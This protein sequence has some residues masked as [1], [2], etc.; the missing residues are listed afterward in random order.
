M[1]VFR[2]IEDCP[3]LDPNSSYCNLLQCSHFANSSVI[4]KANGSVMGF[5]SGYIIPTRPDT[6]FVWQVAVAREARG[7]GLASKMLDHLIA[8]DYAEKIQFLET[9]ITDDNK[10]SWALFQ[11][12]ANNRQ[13][14]LTTSN[15]MDRH[16]HFD[17][18]HDS[19]LLVRIGPFS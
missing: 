8:R 14:N 9:T 10:P 7:K 2:L 1:Q 18:Q 15:W 6:L 11:H 17:G 12:F 5:I 4:A 19:E 3:P 16:D 13:A